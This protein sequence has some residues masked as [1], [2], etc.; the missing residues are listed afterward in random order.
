M[1]RAWFIRKFHRGR[2]VGCLRIPRGFDAA[3][4]L[5][6][7]LNH[8]YSG[9]GWSY[10]VADVPGPPPPEFVEFGWGI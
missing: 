7:E 8:S 5:A 3:D 9:T 2:Y 4:R 1:R 6:A 10:Q